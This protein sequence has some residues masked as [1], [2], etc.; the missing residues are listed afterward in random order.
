MHCAAES[1]PARE[2]AAAPWLTLNNAY[3]YGPIGAVTAALIKASP[4]PLVLIESRY[5]GE[6][7]GSPQRAAPRRTRR[8]C[9]GRR[10][11]S[12]A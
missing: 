2:W 6:P 8:C 5:E 9:P 3:S 4:L 11:S 12:S 1:S 10:A 7:G